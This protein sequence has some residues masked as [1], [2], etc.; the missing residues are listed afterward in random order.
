MSPSKILFFIFIFCHPCV[1]IAQPPSSGS[2]PV[3]CSVQK[4]RDQ[5]TDYFEGELI[6]RWLS[7][8][9]KADRFMELICDFSY[10]DPNGKKWTAPSGTRVNGASIPKALWSAMGSPFVGDYRRASVIHDYYCHHH[11]ENWQDVHRMF[12]HASLADGVKKDKAK[13]L[14]AGV[15]TGEQFGVDCGKNKDNVKMTVAKSKKLWGKYKD[16]F[17]KKKEKFKNWIKKEDPSLEEIEKEAS[18]RVQD[19]IDQ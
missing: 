17:K 7:H 12:Y 9:E 3:Q 11:A 13:M 19:L 16:K 15:Y 14:Y 18:E 4:D 2:S 1:V 8:K 5:E 6:T 10:V